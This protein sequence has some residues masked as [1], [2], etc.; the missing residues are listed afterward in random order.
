MGNRKNLPQH[1]TTN[2]AFCLT[3][4]EFTEKKLHRQSSC[5]SGENGRRIGLKNPLWDIS[6]RNTSSLA[7]HTKPLVL[8][9]FYH[10]YADSPR[11]W[12]CRGFLMKLAQNLAQTTIAETTPP[13][14][15]KASELGSGTNST[16]VGGENDV[17]QG[18]IIG[19]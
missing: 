15:V 5:R 14:A 18:G 13:T 12:K 8:L 7:T 9:R 3:R 4:C 2:L 16:G 1:G 6:D 11:V 17:V 19:S 10:F